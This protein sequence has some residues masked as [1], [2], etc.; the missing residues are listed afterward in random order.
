MEDTKSPAWAVTPAKVEQV[1]KKVVSHC[2]PHKI[3]LF[4]SYVRGQMNRNSDLDLLVILDDENLNCM[5][6]E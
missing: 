3:I 4:G 2:H 6:R 1:L 5:R